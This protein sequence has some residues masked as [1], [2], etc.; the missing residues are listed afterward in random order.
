MEQ[1]RPQSS[2]AQLDIVQ[3]IIGMINLLKHPKNAKVFFYVA[4]LD[5]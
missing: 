2:R 3:L 4:I 1:K 5:H